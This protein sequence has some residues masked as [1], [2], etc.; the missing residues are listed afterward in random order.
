MDVG[1]IFVIALAAVVPEV[2]AVLVTVVA[3][4]LL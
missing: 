3:L 2:L 4:L 1:A